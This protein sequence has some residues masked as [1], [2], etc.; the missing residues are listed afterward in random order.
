MHSGGCGGWFGGR[1]ELSAMELVPQGSYLLSHL[2]EAADGWVMVHYWTIANITSLHMEKMKNLDN[3]NSHTCTC[4]HVGL[5]R[6][7]YLP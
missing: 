5:P 7:M 1:G 4:A 3:D 2:Q 6:P